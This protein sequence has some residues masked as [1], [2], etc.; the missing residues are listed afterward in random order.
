MRFTT[1]LFGGFDGYDIREAEPLNNTRAIPE[2]ATELTH[3]MYYSVKKSMDIL[4][5][6]E[7]VEMNLVNCS[8]CYK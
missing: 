3:A 8:G 6:P 1:P 4:A 5:D 2:S 7:F